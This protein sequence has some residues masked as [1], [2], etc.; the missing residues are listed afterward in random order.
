MTSWLG[1]FSSKKEA[2]AVA[3]V[4]PEIKKSDPSSLDSRLSNLLQNIPNLPSGLQSS[5]FANASSGNNTPLQDMSSTPAKKEKQSEV[6]P[7][8]ALTPLK[9]DYS[10]QNTPLQ[11]EDSHS[12]FNKLVTSNKTQS[13]KDILKGL[14]NLIQSAAGDKEEPGKKE[15]FSPFSSTELYEQP[16][17][18]STFIKSISSQHASPPSTYFSSPSSMPAPIRTITGA[19]TTTVASYQTTT[20][21]NMPSYSTQ[22]PKGEGHLSYIPSLVPSTHHDNFNFPK[23]N[24]VADEY[25]P[26]M[27]LFN[28]DMDLENPDSDNDAPSPDI[29][30]LSSMPAACD[31]DERPRASIPG[32]RLS[33]LITVVT[34][35]SPINNTPPEKMF[36]SDEMYKSDKE[37]VTQE[38][39]PPW[40]SGQPIFTDTSNTTVPEHVM[41]NSP[42]E[43]FFIGKSEV[44]VP[45][46][47]S[48]PVPQPVRPPNGDGVKYSEAIP[49]TDQSP[50]SRIETVQSHRGEDQ[51]GRWFGNNWT[52]NNAQNVPEGQPPRHYEPPEEEFFNHNRNFP[53]NNF[54]PRHNWVPRHRPDMPYENS[55]HQKRNHS[56]SHRPY[57][58]P[59]N[60][61]FLFRGRG[62]NRPQY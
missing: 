49:P 41:K 30:P 35:D 10:G 28:T 55:F 47:F 45:S 58:P 62:W 33:T 59:P 25:N 32:R 26:E 61:R 31:N 52:E 40:D 4:K 22:S 21:N 9:D 16:G 29:E 39:R 20:F 43:E 14:T 27:E 42:N 37:N 12:F 57:G 50:L 60:K 24:F 19:A 3:P 53:P 13:P 2:V 44:S 54:Q 51:N 38:L 34:E 46:Y 36:P 1:A 18:M 7:P 17:G 56:F 15:K 5:L 23:D 8:G 6:P 11:D 48:A